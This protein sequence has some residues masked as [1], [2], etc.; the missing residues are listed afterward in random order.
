MALPSPR[1]A[2][3]ERMES[4]ASSI[5]SPIGVRL[6]AARRAVEG[7]FVE[8]GDVLAR[9]VD[10]V[11]RLISSLDNLGQVLDSGAVEATTAELKVAA[12]SLVV[13]PQRH[14]RRRRTVDR[15]IGLAEDL[16]HCVDEMRRHMGYLWVFA[17]NIKIS[18]AGVAETGQE[19]GLFAQEICDRI[20]QGRGQ[21]G[22]F[23]AE[24][25][26]LSDELQ[27]AHG[28][29]EALAVH[30]D[31]L[32]PAVP[33]G[34]IAGAEALIDQRARIAAAAQ[35][36]AGLARQ[37][38]RKVGM[39]LGAL[40]IGDITRQR[41]EH[42]QTALALVDEARGLSQ[43]QHDRLRALVHRLLAAQLEATAADFHRDVARI[44]QN[45]SEM[46]ADAGELMR[47]RDLA[48][49][50]DKEGQGF[51]QRME[52]HVTQAQGLVGEMEAA[53]H[54]ATAVAGSAAAAATALNA[55][56]AGLQSI[57]TDVQQMALNTMLKCGRVG[58]SGKPLAV[59]ATELRAYANQM[60]QSAQAAMGALG[61][62]TGKAQ[63]MVDTPAQEG[64]AGEA[65]TEASAR[66]RQAAEG[67]A[68]DLRALADL[69]AA[70]V[71]DLKKASTGL[72]FQIEIGAALD[73]A[74][75]A[76]ANRSG[77]ETLDATGV[78][79]IFDDIAGRIAK[80]Y[81]MAQ[82]RIVHQAFVAA[83]R[84]AAEAGSSQA[85]EAAPDELDDVLF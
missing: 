37:I 41:I 18:A 51:L 42:V 3:E 40:Q 30:C 60:D 17:I 63:D 43:A 77:P 47:L 35:D 80:S 31:T 55:R 8:A 28:E 53:D 70:V 15:M 24:L 19:F 49:G 11:G 48:F 12:A 69:G 57:K 66:L 39:V 29:E 67:V 71:K 58:D 59:I 14:G 38:H 78:E 52:G 81:T 23:D 16:R 83:V 65:L 21:L 85:P 50:G 76:L 73:A 13:L 45:M 25:K 82:E 34:L 84:P 20:E 64:G 22:G 44:G 5:A 7:R 10:G 62:L 56:I 72:D 54:A 26:V 4:A 36:V 9:A 27:A 32:L 33:D 2:V 46:A 68:V 61:E 75:V 79:S 74:A 1:L 6:D